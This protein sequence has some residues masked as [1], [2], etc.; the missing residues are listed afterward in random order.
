MSAQ[1]SHDQAAAEN[2]ITG[3]LKSLFALSEASPDLKANQN[4]AQ[5][6]EELTGTEGASPYARQFYSDTVY[7]YNTKVQSFPANIL[8]GMFR[9]SGREYFQADDESRG[10]DAG[11]VLTVGRRLTSG[12]CSTRSRPT[13]GAAGCS[14][15]ASSCSWLVAAAFAYLVGGWADRHRG[16]PGRGRWRQRS[17]PTGSP[18]PWRCAWAGPGRPRSRSTPATT[19]SS[20]ACASPRA[21]RSPGCTWSTTRHPT[22][23]PPGATPA[24]PRWP[25][26]P[27]LLE[28]MNRIELEGVLAHELSHVKNYD[29]LVSTLAVTMVGVV[30]LLADLGIR[31]QW[32]GMGRCPTATTTAATAATAAPW[33]SRS[34]GSPCCPVAAHRPRALRTVA[35]GEPLADVSGS[36]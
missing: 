13:S 26:P 2:Q 25:S 31:L 4:F 16:R 9:F 19:T 34:S 18:T 29:I 17:S 30:A 12:R 10:A 15:P 20:R 33:R 28:K 22:P 32:W 14:S 27:G 35:A 5:L 8:A 23:S 11:V 3:A 1:G 6:Q 24:T 21:S 7:R 36:R